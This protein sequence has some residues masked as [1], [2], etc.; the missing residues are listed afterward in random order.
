MLK[1]GSTEAVLLC[2][3][4]GFLANVRSLIAGLVTK[5]GF[6]IPISDG[7][8]SD[9]QK[10]KDTY[11]QHHNELA[12]LETREAEL[13]KQLSQDYGPNG[14]FVTLRDRCGVTC[15]ESSWVPLQSKICFMLMRKHSSCWASSQHYRQAQTTGSTAS[16]AYCFDS[17]GQNRDPLIGLHKV[18]DAAGAHRCAQEVHKIRPSLKVSSRYL[19]QVLHSGCGQVCV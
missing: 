14:E 13:K 3:E 12:A 11:W 1:P 16:T 2:A 9:G 4:T 19:A 17:R 10:I 5:L 18:G 8:P 6:G 15:R 7:V